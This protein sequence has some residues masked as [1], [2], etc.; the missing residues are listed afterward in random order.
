MRRR[1]VALLLAAGAAAQAQ[2]LAIDAAAG[3]YVVG[4]TRAGAAAVLELHAPDGTR[5][6]QFAA[7]PGESEFRF[8]AGSGG[9][10]RLAFAGSEQSS[11]SLQVL[12]QLPRSAQRD[13]EAPRLADFES[14]QLQ[15]WARELG[16][17]SEA[18]WAAV[19]RAGVPLIEPIAST[20]AARV[21]FL[22][23]GA[24]TKSVRLFWPVRQGDQERFAR[25]ASSDVWHYSVRLPLDTRLAYQLA[26]D[27]PQLRDANRLRQR[28]AILATVRS[29]PLNTQRWPAPGLDDPLAASSMLV[30]PAAPAEPWIEPRAGIARGT[31]QTLRYASTKLGNER[32][33]GLY[34]PPGYQP[35]GPPLPLLLL[36]DHEA[37]VTRVPTPTVLDNLIAAGRIPPLVAVLVGNPTRDSR[38]H[39]L[40]CNPT[41][42]DMLAEELLPWLCERWRITADPARTVVAGSSYGGLAATWLGHR[43]PARFGRVLSLSGSFWWAPERPPGALAGGLDDD[44][45]GEWLTRQMARAPKSDVVFF[46]APGRLERSA[47]ADGPGILET[48]RHLRD[49]LIARGQRVHYR[50]FA[51]GHDYINWRSELAEGLIALLGENTR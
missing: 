8:A 43:H 34:L 15:T 17:G 25:H 27:V 36:F 31:V 10:W 48:N 24:Q 5:V 14:P 23:R 20:K 39:E 3:D 28:R 18:F 49:V 44:S 11:R 38:N 32:A 46:L 22:W 35:A 41:F 50:E 16:A 21:T 6:R 9:R 7:G 42:A 33:L 13:E 37:Y 26:P 30:L 47:P 51:G 19:A 12:E 4:S 2:S 40:P 45:E 1:L 29:D